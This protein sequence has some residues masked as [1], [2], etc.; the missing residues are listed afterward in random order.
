[1]FAEYG[2]IT[3]GLANVCE[4]SAAVKTYQAVYW[5]VFDGFLASQQKIFVARL[6]IN[7]LGKYNFLYESILSLREGHERCVLLL[8]PVHLNTGNLRL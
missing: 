6:R 2:L 3:A 4:M 8:I 1:M 5:E 7:Y